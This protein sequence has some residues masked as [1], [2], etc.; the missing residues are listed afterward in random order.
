MGF[1]S[2][3]KKV[4]GS[5]T[6]GDLL[7]FGGSLISGG[8][9]YMGQNSANAATAASTKEMM[10]F[11]ERMRATQ[12]QTSVEDLKKAGLNP[13][14]AYQQ[15]G[16]GTPS[17]ASYTAQNA[18]S[19]GVSSANETKMAMTALRKGSA[20]V[21]NLEEQNKLIPAQVQESIDRARFMRQQAATEIAREF[22]EVQAA[23][24]DRERMDLDRAVGFAQAE[25][26][27]AAKRNYDANS[28]LT[29]LEAARGKVYNRMWE[30]GGK[31]MD[32][33]GNTLGSVLDWFK[34]DSSRRTKKY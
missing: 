22:R 33:T 30:R 9:S 15:G 29:S 32:A 25:N 34:P 5:V 7:S 16:A 6:G 18:A 19:Q 21:K 2:F 3:A 1:G 31:A 14:L 11:Q 10:D 8:M 24:I 4:V 20:E 26:Y 17:G 13:M 12:Y 28:A 23:K 27:L